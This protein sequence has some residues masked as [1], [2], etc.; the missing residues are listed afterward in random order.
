[1]ITIINTTFLRI[2]YYN[3]DYVALLL[4]VHRIAIFDTVF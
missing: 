3:S 1:M 4:L 2:E